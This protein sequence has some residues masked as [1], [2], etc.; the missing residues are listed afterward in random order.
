MANIK[1]PY[2][3]KG[4]R[5]TVRIPGAWYDFVQEC[6]GINTSQGLLEWLRDNYSD[7]F[8]EW[9]GDRT[10]EGKPVIEAGKSYKVEL[11]RDLTTD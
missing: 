9:L 1:K 5:H 10:V 4:R 6:K 3:I 7:E 2:E 8:I 11:V